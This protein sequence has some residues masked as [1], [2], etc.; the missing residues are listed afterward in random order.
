MPVLELALKPDFLWIG[1]SRVV[2]L[3]I[4]IGIVC[5][6]LL[7]VWA[8]VIWTSR[9]HGGSCEAGRL[10]SY[11]ISSKCLSLAVEIHQMAH[12]PSDANK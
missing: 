3:G 8:L 6:L 9:R 12:G 10:Q 4:T 2:G 1:G 5:F 11:D 7:E